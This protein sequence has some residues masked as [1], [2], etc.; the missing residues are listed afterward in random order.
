M[1]SYDFV[2]NRTSPADSVIIER[3]DKTWNW[4]KVGAAEYVIDGA[5]LVLKVKRSILGV[6]DDKSLNLEFKWSDN[7]Q[8]DGNIMDFYVNGDVAPLGRFNYHYF[9]NNSTGLS[10]TAT[11]AFRIYPNPTSGTLNV[12]YP[13][14]DLHNAVLSVFSSSGQKLWTKRL[15]DGISEEQID[16]RFL[17][18]KGIYLLELISQGKQECRK[19]VID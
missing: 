2:F 11:S 8:E 4:N 5:A 9:V 16:L 18:S 19:F 7:M 17:K 12:V 3:S 1:G 15:S 10:E 6:A 14:A 13:S